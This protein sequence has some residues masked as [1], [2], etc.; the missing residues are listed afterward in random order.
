MAQLSRTGSGRGPGF[1]VNGGI[2]VATVGLMLYAG[3]WPFTFCPPNNASFNQSDGG[4]SFSRPAAIYDADTLDAVEKTMLAESTVTLE[5]RLR[6]SAESPWFLSQIVSFTKGNRLQCV[7]GQ[8]KSDL[9]LKTSLDRKPVGPSGKS[10]VAVLGLLRTGTTRDIVI[11]TGPRGTRIFVDDRQALEDKDFRLFGSGTSGRMRLALGGSLTGKYT[12]SGTLYCFSLAGGDLSQRSMQG[13]SAA[14]CAA[15]DSV[16]P[17]KKIMGFAFT[18]PASLVRSC[19]GGRHALAVRSRFPIIGGN[20][21]VPFWNDFT[22]DASYYSDIAVNVIGFAPF[23]FFLARFLAYLQG[24]K[25]RRVIVLVVVAGFAFSLGIELAQVFLP[26]RS[27]QMSDLICDT[28]G[29]FVGACLSFR[30]P[31]FRVR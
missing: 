15:C 9:V 27:S 31:L 20:V 26:G 28:V 16:G 24:M 17:G 14:D 11:V 10:E 7:V 21:L 13:L 4:I 18:K 23:G 12:W 30:L 5:V 2:T 29:T 25:R 3:L 19:S 22:N 8:W 6:P 1:A